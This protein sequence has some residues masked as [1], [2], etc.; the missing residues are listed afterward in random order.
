MATG[1][2]LGGGGRPA[3]GAEVSV[4]YRWME[5]VKVGE[6][7]PA[8]TSVAPRLQGVDAEEA[9]SLLEEFGKEAMPKAW[10]RYLGLRKTATE[11]GDQMKEL[12]PE[13][14]ASDP[15]GG[16][17]HGKM[18]ARVQTA[19]AEM[20]QRRDELCF[21]RLLRDAGVFTAEALAKFDQTDRMF[22][23]GPEG[24]DYPTDINESEL[25]PS[26]A[27]ESF[28]EKYYPG[29]LAAFR[30]LA[31][32]RSGAA[33][34][35]NQLARTARAMDAV[36]AGADLRILAERVRGIKTR[37]KEVETALGVA[38]MQAAVDGTLPEA[39]AEA[40]RTLAQ[41]LEEF[42]KTLPVRTYYLRRTRLA[43][44][45]DVKELGEGEKAGDERRIR[46]PGGALMEMV[47]CP[48]GS[49]V[50]GS[51]A[52]EEGR[53]FNETQH[54]V[55]LTKGFW[56]AKY[57]VTQEQWNSLMPLNTSKWKGDNLPVETV[58][59]DE[60]T[61]FCKKAGMSLP[62]EA[63]WEYACRAG[64]TT[65]LPNGNIRILGKN[66]APALDDVAWYSGNSSVGWNGKDG[67]DMSRRPEMQYPGRL[68][69]THPVGRKLPNAWGLHDMI[70]NVW[71]WCSD[72]CDTGTPSRGG[73]LE[74]IVSRPRQIDD[75]EV[76]DYP[77][78]DVVDPVGAR[79]GE[80]YVIRGGSWELT[81]RCRSAARGYA[82]SS[83]R[84]EGL[85]FRPCVNVSPAGGGI[86]PVAK[87][88]P[89]LGPG[90]AAGETKTIS[91]PGGERMEMVW[92]PSGEYE[93][94]DDE[95]RRKVKRV[96]GF[97]MAK[98]EV[99][100]AQW[101][102]VIGPNPS[103]RKGDDLPVEQVSAEDASEFCHL[104]GYGL[105]LPTTMEWEYA[106]LAG[107]AGPYGKPAPGGT[108]RVGDM[109][110]SQGCGGSHPVGR[111]QPN[112]WGLH[113]MHGNVAEWCENPND[114]E[115][116]TRGGSWATEAADCRFDS[117]DG[118]HWSDERYLDVG[119][120]PVCVPR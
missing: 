17:Y 48:P 38:R 22:C 104:A 71:E 65:A 98:T 107:G 55:T 89:P 112:A 114:D 86:V 20:F 80:F 82:G 66:N 25:L 51:P 108:G 14:K 84:G 113:D 6:G 101:R 1:M 118:G 18:L 59:Y 41:E 3:S 56:L 19:V 26:V 92:C 36:R 110:W 120:R 67:K 109:A 50:M 42:A 33:A 13:G 69:G 28:A 27:N 2:L 93:F 12:F 78:R 96:K 119:F 47:W 102:F 31:R 24:I 7:M 111:K 53:E 64:S 70:G 45:V 46:L 87:N 37:L 116:F 43:P 39:L 62:T 97:W 34:G 73:V 94:V 81:S 99:T 90:Q 4:T 49:F 52:T 95:G 75:D 76:E 15:S 103:D 8:R 63:Q 88:V 21:F 77:H 23:L 9:E 35:Y 85:G 61:D 68:A 100:Q 60:C 11:L 83:Y 5:P 32:E 105:R 40:D 58:R 72:R 29:T 10:D 16:E 57:E 30:A 91:L 115:R 44:I 74:E 106:C 54:R 79:K 117:G